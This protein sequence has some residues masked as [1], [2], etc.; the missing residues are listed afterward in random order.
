MAGELGLTNSFK[1]RV[2]GPLQKYRGSDGESGKEI[3]LI[4]FMATRAINESGEALGGINPE[5]RGRLG[6]DASTLERFHPYRSEY[7]CCHSNL[8]R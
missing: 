8:L 2:Y 6:L 7:L 3:S 4:D 5:P 1:Q